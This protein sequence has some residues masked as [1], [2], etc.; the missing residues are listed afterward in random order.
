MFHVKQIMMMFHVK[1]N[2][3]SKLDPDSALN[4]GLLRQN[5][6]YFWLA[7]ILAILS[8]LV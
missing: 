7:K 5:R 1:H 2:V 6:R 4:N 8:Q 3:L